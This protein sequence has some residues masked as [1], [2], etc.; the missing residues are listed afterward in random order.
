MKK[1]NIGDIVFV[2]NYEYKNGTNGQ[3]SSF[4]NSRN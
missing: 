2:S 1:Y 4:L 3:K